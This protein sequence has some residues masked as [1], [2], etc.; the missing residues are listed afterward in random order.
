M[1]WLVCVD[2]GA[3]A[4]VLG[5]LPGEVAG[6]GLSPMGAA[7]K[8]LVLRALLSVSQMDL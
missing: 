3:G 1:P 7:Q 8:E 4:S 5:C 6:G 2:M